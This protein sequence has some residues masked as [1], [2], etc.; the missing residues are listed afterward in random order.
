MAKLLLIPTFLF[1]TSCVATISTT[2]ITAQVTTQSAAPTKDDC[3]GGG[4]RTLRARDGSSFKNQGQCVS[5]Y[6]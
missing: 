3:K 5:H 2:P 4:W 6:N 1:L